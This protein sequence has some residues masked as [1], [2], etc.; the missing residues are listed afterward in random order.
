MTD[1]TPFGL[2]L[3]QGGQYSGPGPALAL[4]PRPMPVLGYF[5]TCREEAITKYSA[6]CVVKRT[7][8]LYLGLSAGTEVKP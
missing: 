4:G 2:G 1:G 7:I 8:Q 6:R 3:Q 5:D